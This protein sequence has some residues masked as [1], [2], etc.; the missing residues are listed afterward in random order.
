MKKMGRNING[1]D[2]RKPQT[3]MRFKTLTF[4][5]LKSVPFGE[6]WN[7]NKKTQEGPTFTHILQKQQNT[8]VLTGPH[9]NCPLYCQVDISLFPM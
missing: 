9:H 5:L 6:Q 2:D 7:R 8:I 1:Y 3:A 4:F